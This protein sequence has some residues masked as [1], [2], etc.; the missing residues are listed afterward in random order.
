MTSLLMG[1]PSGEVAGPLSV[2]AGTRVLVG[3][4]HCGSDFPSQ[5]RDLLF[6]SCPHAHQ[7]GV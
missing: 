6:A 7:R 4:G 2:G 1:S 3:A 5:G